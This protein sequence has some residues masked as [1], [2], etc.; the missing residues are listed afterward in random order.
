MSRHQDR[1]GWGRCRLGC[2][3][4]LM[5]AAG[6]VA[7]PT[8][9][10]DW[11]ALFADEGE[12]V[13][14]VPVQPVS[15]KPDEADGAASEEPAPRPIPPA[16][17]PSVGIEEIVVTATKREASKRDIPLSID[18]FDARE[19]EQ[20]GATGIEQI[21]AFSPGAALAKGASPDSQNVTLRG[22]TNVGGLRTRAVGSFYGDI[23]LANPS[24]LG[25]QPDLDPF[26]LRAVE[27]LK[28]PQGTLF[29]GSALSGALR[30]M[31]NR[32]VLGEFG[33][34]LQTT[35]GRVSASDELQTKHGA[36]LNLPLRDV[37]ALRVAGMQRQ[38]AGYVDD[39]RAGEAD[40]N[41]HRLDLL[42]GTLSLEP[43]EYFG[44]DLGYLQRRVRSPNSDLV[45]THRDYRHDN[46]FR[47]D[48]SQSDV[49]LAHLEWR[50]ALD[51][52]DL[53]G[54]S[55][56]LRKPGFMFRDATRAQGAQGTGAQSFLLNVVDATQTSHE[57]RLM[58]SEPTR[59]RFAALNE[60]SYV[61]GLFSMRS[62]QT[63]AQHLTATT[64]PAALLG[65]L[66]GG[67]PAAA[68]LEAVRADLAAVADETALFFDLTR[69][70]FGTWE[71]NLGGRFYRQVTDGRTDASNSGVVVS[72]AE[73]VFVEKGFNPKLA[74]SWRPVEPLMLFA[75]ASRGF[76]FGGVNATVPGSDIPPFYKS[77]E[78]W[79]YEL[80]I[81]TTWLDNRLQ[82]DI[83]AF[84][85]DWTD[86]QVNQIFQ[87]A[88]AYL[89]NLSSTRVRGVELSAQ[90]AL[91]W[92][93]GLTGNLAYVDSH[94]AE[95]FDSEEGPIA[96]GTRSAFTPRRTGSVIGSW[97]AP[98]GDWQLGASVNA[99]YSDE[100]KA[101]L[102]G[103]IRLES[104]W[105]YG[106]SL[107]VQRPDWAG[108]PSLGL[109]ATN[110]SNERYLLNASAVRDANNFTGVLAQPRTVL[111]S[112]GIEW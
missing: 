39:T 34:R 6:A 105:T 104:Y 46:R 96:A 61:L 12:P 111:L 17:A 62:D 37:A 9:D 13:Q 63:L 102:S 101:N 52:A 109:S 5:I 71:L 22:I 36:V 87:N 56:R 74:L 112:L 76:R 84:A 83:T 30:Y 7:Q 10:D 97:G 45:D 35:M 106:A 99:A 26:D 4:M 57:L 21:I 53:T 65:N 93:F 41:R 98:I 50:Y 58:S 18:A 23:S 64:A 25:I 55:A 67:S 38:D 1:S 28:G 70:F 44:L 75:A 90:T 66:L 49:S 42:R 11:D 88:I 100:R 3:G 14:S 72:E 20:S 15:D 60:W 91:P 73:A 47:E 43:T 110:L 51:F 33:G 24:L 103:S 59:S 81:R 94:T 77:D 69:S 29:G 82:A 16:R 54:I 8:D 27:V 68:D 86:Q 79:N 92:G 31:P 40:V 48:V 32:P 108:A 95:D 80:G 19:L 85:I 107:Q 78:I 2:L 89:D